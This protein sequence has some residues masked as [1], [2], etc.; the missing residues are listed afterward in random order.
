M[1][2]ALK[3]N[4]RITDDRASESPKRK[5]HGGWSL[6][7]NELLDIMLKLITAFFSFAEQLS[8]E[9]LQRPNILPN[10]LPNSKILIS[11]DPTWCSKDPAF[12]P[13]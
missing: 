10:I 9:M 5:S 4:N 3:M 6:D 13:A 11:D 12:Y 8:S 1:D 2:N 7:K